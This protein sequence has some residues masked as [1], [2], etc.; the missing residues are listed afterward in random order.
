[1]RHYYGASLG[2][3][4][5]YGIGDIVKGTKYTLLNG[6]WFVD[7]EPVYSVFYIE[8]GTIQMVEEG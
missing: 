6:E 7:D 3:S 1:M 4:S 8:N 5:Y 2:E